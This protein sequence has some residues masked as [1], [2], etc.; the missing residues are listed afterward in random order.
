MPSPSLP[1]ENSIM[2]NTS[3]N[4]TSTLQTKC[5]RIALCSAHAIHFFL[6]STGNQ[7]VPV[8]RYLDPNS[9]PHSILLPSLPLLAFVVH[10]NKETWNQRCLFLSV[11]TLLKSSKVASTDH[12]ASYYK[13]GCTLTWTS[14][15]FG[16]IEFVILIVL[17][18]HF[19]LH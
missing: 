14:I 3:L 1:R 19:C 11:L 9:Q 15:Q 5:L 16:W 4:N 12:W 10:M 8:F 13:L 17:I 7:R 2:Q 6:S 18:T